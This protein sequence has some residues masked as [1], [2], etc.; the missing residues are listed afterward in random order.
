MLQK[1]SPQLGFLPFDPIHFDR[2]SFSFQPIVPILK[3]SENIDVWGFSTAQILNV[4]TKFK[5][6]T[7]RSVVTIELPRIESTELYRLKS[8]EWFGPFQ[9]RGTNHFV[10]S[11]KG[12]YPDLT[13]LNNFCNVLAGIRVTITLLCRAE[14]TNGETY[15]RIRDLDFTNNKFKNLQIRSGLLDVALQNELVITA[16][17]TFLKALWENKVQEIFTA[18]FNAVPLR[19]L[20]V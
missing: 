18:F 1:G 20:I 6:N 7:M 5:N 2:L 13:S 10:A 19:R 14:T 15:M 12:S 16:Y 4:K 17:E 9:P 8:Q 3:V 11:K